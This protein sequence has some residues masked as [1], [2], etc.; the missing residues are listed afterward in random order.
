ML[1]QAVA[2]GLDGAAPP[3]HRP[4]D[5]TG[6]AV[7]EATRAV[8]DWRSGSARRGAVRSGAVR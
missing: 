3:A 1:S 8:A 5:W 2:G 6:Q 4:A 7:D